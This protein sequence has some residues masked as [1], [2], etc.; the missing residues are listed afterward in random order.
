MSQTNPE[1]A[2]SL[3]QFITVWKKI[4]RPFTLVDQT[5]RPGLAITWPCVPEATFMIHPICQP[6]QPDQMLNAKQ[7]QDLADGCNI[8]THS[9]A[10]IIASATG[11]KVEQ[12]FADV[13]QTRFFNAEQSLSYGLV[14]KIVTNFF[15]AGTTYT[16]V[17]ED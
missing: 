11:Q 1:L 17:D 3:Q 9:I 7:F 10:V 13:N 14:T 4:G 16:V 6:V 2:E 8:Q 15:P 12:V 5:D